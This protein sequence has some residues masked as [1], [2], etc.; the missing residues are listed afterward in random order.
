LTSEA[1][2]RDEPAP[3]TSGLEVGALAAALAA[4]AV[5]VVL[6]LAFLAKGGRLS[7]DLLAEASGETLLVL[8]LVWLALGVAAVVCAVSALALA[9][10]RRP[11]A[12]AALALGVVAV[13]A[14]AGSAY[15]AVATHHPSDA[16]L[17]ADFEAHESRFTAL[18]DEVTAGHDVSEAELHALG[19]ERLERDAGEVVLCVSSSGIVSAGSAKG[20]LYAL[21]PPAPLIADL[22]HDAD[23][24]GFSYRH[25]EGPWYLYFEAW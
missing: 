5:G 11:R 18:V 2:A 12:L 21:R 4:T 25:L 23:P 16:T 1:A 13:L 14:V 7:A 22:D 24:V 10:R 3:S 15:L 17:I 8:G 19:V 9:R 20:Y 6:S